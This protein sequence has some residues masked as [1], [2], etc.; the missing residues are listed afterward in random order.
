MSESAKS[1]K[2]LPR[3][4][5]PS[6][7]DRRIQARPDLDIEVARYKDSRFFAVYLK[8]ELLAVTVYKKGALAIRMALLRRT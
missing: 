2:N 7:T 3:S 6:A 4:S 8:G 5:D 1:K